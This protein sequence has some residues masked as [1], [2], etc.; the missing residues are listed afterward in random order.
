M[1]RGLLHYAPN[2]LRKILSVVQKL[3]DHRDKLIG[4]ALTC[5]AG[6]NNSGSSAD[7]LP[8]TGRFSAPRNVKTTE[9]FVCIE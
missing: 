1:A 8:A 5:Y 3:C 9:Y 2:S 7:R 6:N 4:V